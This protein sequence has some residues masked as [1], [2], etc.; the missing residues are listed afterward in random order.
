MVV[1]RS[2]SVYKCTNKML[3]ALCVEFYLSFE[4]FNQA[5]NSPQDGFK[6]CLPDSETFTLHYE[7]CLSSIGSHA[8]RL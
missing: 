8:I 6:S 4:I 3:D 1:F 2:K 7:L 5:I